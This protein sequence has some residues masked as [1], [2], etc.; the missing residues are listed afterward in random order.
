MPLGMAKYR[1]GYTYSLRPPLCASRTKAVHRPVD[2][3]AHCGDG[4]ADGRERFAIVELDHPP[5]QRDSQP[6]E[7]GVEIHLHGR[8][9]H[10]R[11]QLFQHSHSHRSV[12]NL[13]GALKRPALSD[14]SPL[15]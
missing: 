9:A 2:P 4:A 5:K 3:S 7:E 12:P 6:E 8:G 11:V 13:E 15:R 1:T 14:A 10:L